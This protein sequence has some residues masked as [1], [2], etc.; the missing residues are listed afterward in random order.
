MS[1]VAR[2]RLGAYEILA[3]IGSGGMGEVYRAHHPRIGREVAIKVLPS[4]WSADPE[5][6]ARF[7][8]EARAAAA[9]NHAN[10]LAVHDLGRDGSTTYLVTELL[11]GETL[12]EAIAGPLPVKKAIDYAIQIASG[13]VPTRCSRER[14]CRSFKRASRAA[15]R[16]A[17]SSISTPSARTGSGFSSTRRRNR[18]RPCR[19]RSS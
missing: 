13:R 8:Q 14:R 4:A 11:E 3:A 1:L 7:E 16:P 6:L 17:T 9:L 2:N 15:R 5:R 19:S 18:R 10:I 12:R